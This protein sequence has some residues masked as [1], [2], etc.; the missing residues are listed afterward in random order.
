MSLFNT[1]RDHINYLQSH[2]P[3]G[4][5]LVLYCSTHR[6]ETIYAGKLSYAG[7]DLVVIQGKDGHGNPSYVWANTQ[8]LQLTAKIVPLDAREPDPGPI[9]FEAFLDHTS[10]TDRS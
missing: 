7:P 1:L 3:D 4:H 5:R 2:V 9:S 10:S 8:A 6:G